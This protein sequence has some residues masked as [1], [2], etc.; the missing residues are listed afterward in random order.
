MNI[1]DFRDFCL[2]MKGVTEAMPFDDKVLVFKVMNK[3]F[4]LTNI[5]DFSSIN[6]K[7]EPDKAIELRAQYDAVQPGYHMSKKHWNTIQL[8]GSIDVKQMKEWVIDSYELIVK[9]LSKKLQQE[10]EKEN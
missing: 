2:K 9:G 1:E 5:E 8:D 7:C 10:L 6:V 4:C 3:M